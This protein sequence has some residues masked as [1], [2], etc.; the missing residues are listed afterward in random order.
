MHLSCQIF[1]FISCAFLVVTI[2][3]HTGS[4]EG[5]TLLEFDPVEGEIP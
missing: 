4:P 1:I 5:V 3:H 2:M